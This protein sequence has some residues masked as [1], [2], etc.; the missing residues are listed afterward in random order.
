[1]TG[2][3]EVIR[4]YICKKKTLHTERVR[5]VAGVLLLLQAMAYEVVMQ[6]Q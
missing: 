3:V 4:N 5:Q 1:M 6:R 2:R